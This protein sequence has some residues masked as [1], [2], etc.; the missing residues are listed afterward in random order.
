MSLSRITVAIT[1][2]PLFP[3]KVGVTVKVERLTLYVQPV[4]SRYAFTDN[5]D[6]LA[7]VETSVV[8]LDRLESELRPRQSAVL[9]RS[10]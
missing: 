2:S 4:V 7:R 8:S 5:V 9:L 6:R 3:E 1:S 10:V